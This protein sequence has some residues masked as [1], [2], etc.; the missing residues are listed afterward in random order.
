MTGRVALR[1]ASFLAALSLMACA[2]TAATDSSC[3]S[4]DRAGFV[5]CR[6]AMAIADAVAVS[7]QFDTSQIEASIRPEPVAKGRSVP[8]WFVTAHRAVFRSRSGL[9]CVVDEYTVVVEAATGRLLAWD[10]P[11][12]R[13]CTAS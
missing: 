11:A 5:G 8:A 13:H 6:E 10:E 4:E 9:R 7:H 3:R 1:G 2:H 12:L